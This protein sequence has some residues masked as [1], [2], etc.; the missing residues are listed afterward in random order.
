MG[1]G[2]T[3]QQGEAMAGSAGIFQAFP[4][5]ARGIS[6]SLLRLAARDGVM[7][8]FGTQGYTLALRRVAQLQD[9]VPAE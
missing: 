9:K 1:A 5:R 6:P 2:V 4:A 7:A 3:G 8:G